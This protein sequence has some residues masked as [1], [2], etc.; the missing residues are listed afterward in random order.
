MHETVAFV[1]PAWLWLV[2]II[3]LVMFIGACGWLLCWA[4]GLRVLLR[5]QAEY[6]DN[7]AKVPEVEAIAKS[8]SGRITALE[9]AKRQTSALPKVWDGADEESTTETVVSPA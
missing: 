3:A 9:R 5:K 4:L 8:L 6:H 2:T 7:A 1:G